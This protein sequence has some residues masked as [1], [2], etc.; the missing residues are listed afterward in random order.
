MEKRECIACRSSNTKR[1]N[2]RLRHGKHILV[3]C[4]DCGL[5]FLLSDNFEILDDDSYWDEVN[6]KIYVMPIVLREFK[7]KQ[8]K[9]LQRIHKMSPPNN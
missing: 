2:Y 8:Y 4:V 6:K 9:Y 1:L 3:K 5:M 7:K